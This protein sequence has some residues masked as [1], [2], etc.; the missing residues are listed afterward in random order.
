MKQKISE[1]D[2]QKA[3]LDYLKMRGI[4]A[5]RQNVGSFPVV[6]KNGKKRYIRTGM[7]GLP[8]ILV[9]LPKVALFLEI[10][11]ERGRLST[12]QKYFCKRAEELGHPCEVCRS[13]EDVERAIKPYLL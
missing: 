9:L 7:K 2:I 3:I 12:E 10:K 8:D 5:I 6:D 1:H 4:I 11:S 13:V